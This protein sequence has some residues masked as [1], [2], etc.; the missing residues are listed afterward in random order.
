MIRFCSKKCFK[1]RD[2][3][4]DTD[5]GKPLF[6]ESPTISSEKP[7]TKSM[8]RANLCSSHLLVTI[9]TFLAFSDVGSAIQSESFSSLGRAFIITLI[10]GSQEFVS[11]GEDGFQIRTTTTIESCLKPAMP[12]DLV[13]ARYEISFENGTLISTSEDE[14]GGGPFHFE[15]GGAGVIVGLNVVTIEM[16]IGEVR[17]AIIPPKYAWGSEVLK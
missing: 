13:Q 3:F 12:G 6:L 11:V 1:C 16:C 17:E 10:T 5:K 9:L 8:M 14:H 7:H 4:S 15:L 2:H